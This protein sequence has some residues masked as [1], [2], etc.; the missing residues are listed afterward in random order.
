MKEAAADFMTAVSALQ[1]ENQRH[2]EQM[3]QI[4]ADFVEAVAHMGPR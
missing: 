3:R 2:E 4:V 1:Y